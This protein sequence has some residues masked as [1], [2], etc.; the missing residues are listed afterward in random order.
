MVKFKK[1]NNY[2]FWHSPLALVILLIIIVLFSYNIVDL[3]K[4][5]RETSEKK[6]LVLEKIKYYQLKAESLNT[7]ISNLETEEGKEEELRSKM[8]Y[9]RVGEKMVTIVE[10]K[11]ETQN[12]ESVDNSTSG[13]NRFLNIFKKE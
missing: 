4:K 5:S 9:T 11:E 3:V 10:E 13:F 2:K 8:P 1:T 6:N 12:V 7:E